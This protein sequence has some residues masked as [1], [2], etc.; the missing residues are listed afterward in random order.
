MVA[1]R[2]PRPR[3]MDRADARRR[4]RRRWGGALASILGSSSVGE[5]RFCPS[6][7]RRGATKIAFTGGV[8]PCM[9]GA[10]GGGLVRHDHRLGVG[11]KIFLALDLRQ[12]RGAP[13][14]PSMAAVSPSSGAPWS[15]PLF[16]PRHPDP[17]AAEM[18]QQLDH[19]AVL[20]RAR[21]AALNVGEAGPAGRARSSTAPV[22]RRGE[23]SP[24]WRSRGGNRP[25]P[26]QAP[27]MCL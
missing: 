23:R 7:N 8:L 5:R 26:C 10:A 25:R 19:F 4:A 11:V 18:V 13:R 15:S 1:V 12:D 3:R 22:R 6:G 9:A 27:A 14:S 20:R 17:L 2:W 21:G 24:A 16:D